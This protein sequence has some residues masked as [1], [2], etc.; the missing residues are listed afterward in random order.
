MEPCCPRWQM[1]DIQ[2]IDGVFCQWIIVRKKR[3]QRIWKQRFNGATQLRQI[4]LRLLRL[5]STVETCS[6]HICPGSD[7]SISAVGYI[8]ELWS[9]FDPRNCL[10]PPPSLSLSPPPSLPPS[11]SLPPL[12]PPFLSPPS[13]SLSLSLSPLLPSL[14]LFPPLS[15][16]LSPPPSLSPPF[17]SPSLSLSPLSLS[18]AL[19]L[20]NLKVDL[21]VAT[22]STLIIT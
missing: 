9:L 15:L 18:L 17:L 21:F 8:K 2:I 20:Y 5:N 7:S 4:L 12:S 3:K 11:L 14:P 19:S 10:S 13:L 6:D 16:S 1:K 22:L